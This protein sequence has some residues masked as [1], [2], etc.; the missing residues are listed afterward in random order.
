MSSQT[1]TILWRGQ[2]SGPYSVEQIEEMLANRQ[3]SLSHQVNDEGKMVFV[4]DFLAGKQAEGAQLK[5]EGAKLKAEQ[6]AKVAEA[7]AQAEHQRQKELVELDIARTQAAAPPPPVTGAPP[8]LGA[9]PIPAPVPMPPVQG[10]NSGVLEVIFALVVI[11]ALGVGGWFAYEHYFSGPTLDEVEAETMTLIQS[12][13]SSDGKGVRIQSITLQ[14][15]G[16][17]RYTGTAL[18]KHPNLPIP[19][20]CDVTAK[21]DGEEIDWTIIP[22]T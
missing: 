6:E 21:V 1:Y 12:S 10:S 19:T 3:V 18:V 22:R 4:E 5:A 8:E 16:A 14:E 17:G 7:K 20:T 15:T 13:Y 11:G 2:T 9:P